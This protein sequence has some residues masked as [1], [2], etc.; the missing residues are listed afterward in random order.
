[1][2]CSAEG[3]VFA[4]A[5]TSRRKSMQR[6]LATIAA[7]AGA[8]A[9]LA[10]AI[11]LAPAQGSQRSLAA[12]SPA[13]SVTTLPQ[14]PAQTEVQPTVEPTYAPA[15]TPPPAS[16]GSIVA[17]PGTV[18]QI[19]GDVGFPKVVTLK[20]LQQMQHTSLTMRVIDP[21]G[22]RRVHIFTGVL[23]R[24]LITETAPTAPG[25]AVSSTSAYA[26]VEGV[27]GEM[28]LIAFPEF[29]SAFDNK[30]IIVAYEIDGAPLNG[31]NIGELIVPE[32]QTSGRFI[33][34]ITTIRIGSPSP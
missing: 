6:T 29:E 34:G 23:L 24:D 3:R 22:K 13:V 7:V 12:P 27:G 26:L 15:Y 31:Q 4:T 17:P 19:V 2:F 32:D 25:G 11:S 20:D 10:G 14:L 21:D 5:T 16:S 33:V 8:G 28:A 1:V 30:R 18:I 9:T